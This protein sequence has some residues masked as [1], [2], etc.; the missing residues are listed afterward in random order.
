M[1][2]VRLRLLVIIAFTMSAVAFGYGQEAAAPRLDQMF[3]KDVI[4]RVF[5][6][7]WRGGSEFVI[8]F[9]LEEHWPELQIAFAP[10]KNTPCDV[11]F[12]YVSRGPATIW[13]QL[14]SILGMQPALNADEAARQVD[15][16][17]ERR[18]L[19]CSSRLAR[20]LWRGT[21]LRLQME[22]SDALFIHGSRYSLEFRSIST[23][24]DLTIAGPPTG[25]LSLRGINKWLN[26]V[27]IEAERYLGFAGATLLSNSSK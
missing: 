21:D 20:L 15:V 17:R 18:R 2:I 14:Q 7:E 19:D 23:T 25:S 22:D 3:Y 5:R 24:V 27:H 6:H 8:R 9:A 4:E 26:D 12:W 16:A 13:D 10:H 11:D 1:L